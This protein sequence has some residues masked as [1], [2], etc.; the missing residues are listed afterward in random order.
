M[1]EAS[2]GLQAWKVLEDLTNH[3][4]LILSEVVMPCVSGIGL[5]YKIMSHKSRKNIPVISKLC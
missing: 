5:L 3:V 1:I 2:N 4:D